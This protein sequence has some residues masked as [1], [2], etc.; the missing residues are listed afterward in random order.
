MFSDHTLADRVNTLE[1][2]YTELFRLQT[3]HHGA[4]YMLVHDELKRVLEEAT[5]YCELGVNQG[6]TLGTALL[7]SNIRVARAYD[8]NLKPYDLARHMFDEYASKAGIDLR[9]FEADTLTCSVDEVDV[10]YID[11]K[12]YY[13]HLKKELARHGHKVQQYIV[14]HDTVTGKNLDRAVKEY[15]QHNNQWTIVTDCKTDVGFMTIQRG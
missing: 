9:V 10:M 8:I 12:H 6:T 4:D 7:L 15:V 1:E 5:S 11:T 3:H 2:Y 14:F 13:D